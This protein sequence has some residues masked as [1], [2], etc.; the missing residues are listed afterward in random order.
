MR[1][2]G[3]T[4]VEIGYKYGITKQAVFKFLDVDNL[5]KYDIDLEQYIVEK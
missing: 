3:Y 4:L 1:K 5:R 2:E